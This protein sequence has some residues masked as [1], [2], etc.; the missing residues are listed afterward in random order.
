MPRLCN[1]AWGTSVCGYRSIVLRG[2]RKISRSVRSENVV[3]FELR[4]V[5]CISCWYGA[6]VVALGTNK[7]T[8]QWSVRALLQHHHAVRVFPH[9]SLLLSASHAWFTVFA[10]L[11]NS[12][13]VV[14][15]SWNWSS[16]VPEALWL[17]TG[18]RDGLSEFRKCV[19]TFVSDYYVFS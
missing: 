1:S 14:V 3:W 7:A 16:N 6:V 5:C 10:E 2:C 17:V 15:R 19:R 12:W 13:S 4:G 11:L 9:C 8:F 18:L